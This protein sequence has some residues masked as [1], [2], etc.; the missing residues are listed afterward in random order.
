MNQ[1]DSAVPASVPPPTEKILPG[2]R[3]HTIH[4]V[5]SRRIRRYVAWILTPQVLL[6][7]VLG[8]GANYSFEYWTEYRQERQVDV[9][10][11]SAEVKKISDLMPVTSDGVAKAIIE[12]DKLY[13][14][15]PSTHAHRTIEY[16]IGKLSTLKAKCLDQERRQAEAKES[17]R[18]AKEK[19]FKSEAAALQAK[20]AEVARS[21]EARR[22]IEVAQQSEAAARTAAVLAATQRLQAV[23]A[24]AQSIQEAH[25]WQRA[26]DRAP[27]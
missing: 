11:V 9:R 8:F 5:S 14:S 6:G 16:S 24:Q 25:R 10:A 23:E 18:A 12:V 17:A 27:R 19:Q 26:I 13:I 4:S 3:P 1:Q 2:S 15:F 20:L 21:A 7:G 22:L